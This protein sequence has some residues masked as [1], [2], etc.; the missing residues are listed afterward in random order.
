MEATVKS[1]ITY[2]DGIN[3]GLNLEK[4]QTP[5]ILFCPMEWHPCGGPGGS[6]DV[7]ALISCEAARMKDSCTFYG[8]RAL[9]QCEGG[10]LGMGCI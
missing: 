10:D 1:L 8:S 7:S 5:F 3:K 2:C 9:G 6:T 4:A